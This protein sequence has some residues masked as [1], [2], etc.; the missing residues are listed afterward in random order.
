MLGKV[1]YMNASKYRVDIAENTLRGLKRSVEGAYRVEDQVRVG[2]HPAAS[3]GWVF[4]LDRLNRSATCWT[5]T[6]WNAEGFFLS[7]CLRMLGIDDHRV[8]YEPPQPSQF[9]LD[10]APSAPAGG[11]SISAT[12]M[13][14][15]HLYIE[16]HDSAGRHPQVS[17][18]H[19]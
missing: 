18:M 7:R 2:T 12:E 4:D 3:A 16:G 14:P 11:E 13:A 1:E 15:N 6:H 17:S 19:A 8:Q 10:E 5:S 9:S